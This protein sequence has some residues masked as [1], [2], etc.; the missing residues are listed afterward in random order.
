MA[1]D[2]TVIM[3]STPAATTTPFFPINADDDLT[4]D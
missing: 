3:A 2:M 1:P 4:P